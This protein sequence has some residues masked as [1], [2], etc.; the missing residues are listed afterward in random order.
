MKRTQIK[1]LAESVI[2]YNELSEKDLKWIYLNLS[3]RNIKLFLLLLSEEIKNSSVVVSFAGELSDVCKAK[4]ID[5]FPNKKIW[6]KRDDENIIG[7][8]RFEY[9][10]FVVD[11]S[12]SGIIKR[13]LNEIREK[14]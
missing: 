5:M 11:Y 3:K 13:T 6:F 4:I 8:M 7:G 1:E 10:D 2:K 12:I 14:L 9:G